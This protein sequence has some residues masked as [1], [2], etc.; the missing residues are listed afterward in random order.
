[1][2]MYETQKMKNKFQR[3]NIII[4]P[5]PNKNSSFI[6]NHTNKNINNNDNYTQYSLKQNYFDPSKSSPPNEFMIK[7][8]MRYISMN[9]NP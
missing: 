4:I 5:N 3:S 2:Q 1:M 8:Y 9:G 6:E 7:L